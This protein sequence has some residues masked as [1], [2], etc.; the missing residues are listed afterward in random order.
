MIKSMTGY[1]KAEG[2]T[3]LGWV[4]VELT[5][6]NHR[7]LDVRLKLPELIRFL[8]IEFRGLLKA[9]LKRGHIE[10]SIKITVD[11]S[12]PLGMP[13][14]NLAIARSF[15]EEVRGFY[16]ATNLTG[17]P[18]PSWIFG[19]PE[20]WETAE[21]EAVEKARDDFLALFTEAIDR[22]ERSRESEGSTLQTFLERK[23][24]EMAPLIKGMETLKNEVPRLARDS[25]EKRLRDLDLDPA[26]NPDRLAQEVVYLAQRADI[27]EEVA[28]LSAH[29][30]TFGQKLTAPETSGRELDFIIQEMNREVNTMGSKSISYELSSLTIQLKKIINQMREQVQNAE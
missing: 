5:S 4:T 16:N 23:L 18:D 20:V 12:S 3:A 26:V 29:V 14:L 22:L 15:Y 2:S 9:K 19:K 1:G 17:S 30:N 10:G 21:P 24:H 25:L 8:D 27:A 11:P 7:N 6:V 13:R 28:R